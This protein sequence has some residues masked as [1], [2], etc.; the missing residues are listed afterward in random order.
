MTDAPD[1]TPI[2]AAQEP[3]GLA[4][5]EAKIAILETALESARMI[6]TAVG[7]LVERLKIAPGDAFDSLVEASHEEHR[8]VPDIASDLVFTGELGHVAPYPLS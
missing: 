4:A 1:R 8:K 7:I 2:A 3:R 5:A 6:G